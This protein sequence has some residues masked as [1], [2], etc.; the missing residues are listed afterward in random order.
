MFGPPR[1]V[2]GRAFPAYTFIPGYTPH[3]VSDPRGHSYGTREITPAPLDATAW[4]TS[5]EYLWGVDLYNHGYP[6][7][8]HE[9]WEG[10]WRQAARGSLLHVHLQGLIQ[11]AAAVVK[12]LAS[13]PAGVASLSHSALAHIDQ[14]I[15]DAGSPYLGVDLVRFARQFRR[16]I[17]AQPFK[18]KKWP[19]IRLQG[20]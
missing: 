3:P 13:T 18:P 1:Y 7:E 10:L 2:P 17:A 4:Q 14:V 8:A 15:A 19:I 9:A 6:W 20:L 11:C 16:Y 12:A 5:T